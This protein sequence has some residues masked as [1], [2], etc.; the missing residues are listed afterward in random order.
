[1]GR[2]SRD[3]ERLLWPM[4][5]ELGWLPLLLFHAYKEEGRKRMVA[6]LA[7]ATGTHTLPHASIAVSM[8]ETKK[9]MSFA[10]TS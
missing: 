5:G 10:I 8:N 1:V 3:E 7:I 6:V 4:V 2:A 9:A